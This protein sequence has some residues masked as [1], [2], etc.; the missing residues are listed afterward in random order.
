MIP[1]GSSEA[2]VGYA[3]VLYGDQESMIVITHEHGKEAKIFNLV[4]IDWAAIPQ[5]L[6]Q[7]S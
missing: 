2:N 3:D 1:P 7:N 5:T 6:G 4:A